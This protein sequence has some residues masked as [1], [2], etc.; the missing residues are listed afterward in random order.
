MT[1]NPNDLVN[2]P[3]LIQPAKL[4]IANIEHRCAA[5]HVNKIANLRIALEERNASIRRFKRLVKALIAGVPDESLVELAN[6]AGIETDDAV[7][8]RVKFAG[9]AW[10]VGHVTQ[11]VTVI[12]SKP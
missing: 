8:L 3:A 2:D 9:E 7:W 4:L 10:P 12:G 6:E 5:K 1:P 11:N